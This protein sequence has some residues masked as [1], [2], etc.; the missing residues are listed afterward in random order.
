MDIRRVLDA[1]IRDVEE[2]N[3]AT[4]IGTERTDAITSG[5]QFLRVKNQKLLLE[6]LQLRAMAD[7]IKALEPAAVKNLCMELYNSYLQKQPGQKYRNVPHW[8][9]EEVVE[10]IEWCKLNV[11][12]QVGRISELPNWTGWLEEV[13][14]ER[15]NI[16]EAIELANIID[17]CKAAKQL[18]VSEFLM[19]HAERKFKE[20][21]EIDEKTPS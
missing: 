6:S 19:Q 21:C 11:D 4:R 7:D 20:A 2:K 1:A 12:S 17:N 8:K 16:G 10:A 18:A 13:D 9:P 15:L 14:V 5:I 3:Q